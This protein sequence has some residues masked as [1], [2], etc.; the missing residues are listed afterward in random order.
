MKAKISLRGIIFDLDG[1]LANTLPV[2]FEA[3]RRAFFEYTNRHLTD[4][5][6]S[7]YFGPSEEGII[8]QVVPSEW[9]A[10]LQKYLDEYEKAH[11]ICPQ[12]FRGIETVLGYCQEK[13]IAVAIVT[14]K[15]K[16]S[17]AISLRYLGLEDYFDTIETGSA[18]GGI[19][20]E[21]IK[22]VLK[23]W[24]ISPESVAYVGDSPSDITDA[25]EVRVIPLAAA[26]AETANLEGLEA[27][28]P[29]ATFTS[30]ENFLDWIR[31]HG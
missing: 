29:L 22:S 11:T 14:G 6:I 28:A 17:A 24:D 3:F 19:K 10:C 31:I 8:Q 4:E 12:P 21:A 7:S 18:N 26:W 30:V 13:N 27:M 25:K 2:C 1:T 15:G 23:K 9:Q 5:E 20:P 16:D